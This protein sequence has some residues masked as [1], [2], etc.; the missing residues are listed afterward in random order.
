[1]SDNLFQKGF[2]EAWP[3]GKKFLG[4]IEFDL[5]DLST[6]ILT[7][8]LPKELNTSSI[9]IHIKNGKNLRYEDKLEFGRVTALAIKSLKEGPGRQLFED[10]AHNIKEMAK[11]HDI[12]VG[13]VS[14]K[15]FQYGNN[16]ECIILEATFP[17]INDVFTSEGKAYA[18]A[19]GKTELGYRKPFEATFEQLQTWMKKQKRLQEQR[20]M[21][22]LR[23][24]PMLHSFLNKDQLKSLIRFFKIDEAV[25]PG[26]EQRTWLHNQLKVRG[27]VIDEKIEKVSARDGVIKA[28]IRLNDSITWETSSS[29]WAEA[30]IKLPSELPDSVMLSCEGKKLRNLI[31]FEL[32]PK[33][34][35]VTKCKQDEFG[36]FEIFPDCKLVALGN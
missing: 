13:Y 4:S 14:A 11:L 30:T 18:I 21:T 35:K 17:E 26:Q 2:L 22:G 6:V 16:S 12:L 29:I 31:D 34:W 20:S 15:A 24:D 36:N 5:N 25:P 33:D 23:M 19:H 27:V 8:H 7:R 28:K 9:A 3:K 10:G 32:I 1:M